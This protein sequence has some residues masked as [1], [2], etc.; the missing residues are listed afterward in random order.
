[1][2]LPRTASLLAL[3]VLLAASFVTATIDE[4]RAEQYES[5][6]NSLLLKKSSVNMPTRLV[7]G[8][9]NKFTVKAAPGSTV[10]LFVSPAE[11]GYVFDDRLP[12]AVG[13]EVQEITGT[14]PATGVLEMTLPLPGDAELEGKVLYV[15]AVVGKASDLSDY[16]RPELLD[17][18]GRRTTENALVMMKPADEG[19]MF[20]TPTIPGLNPQLINTLSTTQ[21]IYQSG[22][23]RRKQ[24][25]NGGDINRDAEIDRNSFNQR[26]L[27]PGVK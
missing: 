18:S 1:M 22:D 25:L 6:L 5:R 9:E 24:L 12:L 11:E 15:D 3:S 23:D 26:G 16:A 21:E 8:Q 27:M 7:L 4:A 20:V 17:S 2:A 13:E 10:R 14:I 19:H